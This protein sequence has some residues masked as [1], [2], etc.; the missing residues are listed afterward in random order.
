MKSNIV[1][2]I[3]IKN[4]I[5]IAIIFILASQFFSCANRGKGPQGGPKDTI[6]PRALKTTPLHNTTNFQKNKIEIEFDE[7][8]VV[9]EVANNV[10]I[11]PPQTKN[12]TIRAVAKKVV[13]EL[14][15]T[16]EENTTYTINFGNAIQD[17]NEG[18]ILKD[19]VFS[20][21]TG[22]YIDTLRMSGMV[23]NAENLNPMKGVFVGIHDNLN[24]SAFTSLAFRRISKSNDEGNFTIHNIKEGEY[25]IF[26]LNDVNK[27]YKHN[28]GEG[29]AFLDKS[30]KPEVT[31]SVRLDTLWSDSLTVD[32]IIRR[33]TLTYKPIDIILKYFKDPNKRQFLVKSER[34]DINQISLVFNAPNQ[35]LPKISFL[36]N[37]N[38]VD[39][40]FVLQHNEN[41]D[42]LIYWL[43]DTT[44]IKKDTIRFELNYQRSDSLMNLEN[45]ID[46][47]RTIIKKETRKQTEQRLEKDQH[48]SMSNNFSNRFDIYKDMVLSFVEPIRE[49]DLEKI[50][51]S[52]YVDTLLKEKDF[53]IQKLDS[54]G[55]KFKLNFPIEPEGKYQLVIDSAAFVNQY[56]RVNKSHKSELTVRSLEEY[57]T[58]TVKL[59]HFD[60]LAVFQVVDS[61]D[62][63]VKT[64]KA[65]SNPTQIE[66][67][68][69]G[70]YYLRMFIDTNKNGKWDGGNFKKKTAPEEVFYYSKELNLIA[71]WE[72]EE[73]WDHR[74][75]PIQHQKPEELIKV[76]TAQKE[77]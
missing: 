25:R 8:V 18:N 23:L 29:L 66:Y 31:S 58:L 2:V 55:L 5:Q 30:F 61:K 17:N 54:V 37:N 42:S 72:F 6:P 67:I 13:A 33:E 74:L 73:L 69:P 22:D 3:S 52:Q 14:N 43:T 26:A 28:I 20:F 60:S 57:A 50:H 36:D 1:Q 65:K 16:L 76:E 53:T 4:I 45:R 47:I 15:D 56:N 24:D 59:A 12:P 48:I 39:K 44:L 27:D 34:A 49:F 11:S 75:M 32:T 71:N 38:G 63:V 9:K 21:S 7:N 40:K 62:V 70:D 51:V 35:E 64:V 68:E 10:V 77:K 46:T 19:Y 41:K